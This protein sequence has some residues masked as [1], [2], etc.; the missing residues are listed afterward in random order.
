[1]AVVFVTGPYVVGGKKQRPTTYLRVSKSKIRHP[2][3]SGARSS[4]IYQSASR[5]YVLIS[6]VPCKERDRSAINSRS[7]PPHWSIFSPTLPLT[8]N[9]VNGPCLHPDI[10][11]VVRERERVE[12]FT[13]YKSADGHRTRKPGLLYEP[14]L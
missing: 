10:F 4:L 11:H 13:N 1:M 8:S 5:S 12:G 2:R 14:K 9:S 6:C 7:L 3:G